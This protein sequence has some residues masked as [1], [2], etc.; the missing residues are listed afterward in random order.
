VFA[1]LWILGAIGVA[2]CARLSG[3]GPW[4]WFVVGVALTPLG[5]S[6]ALMAANRFG[7]FAAR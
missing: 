5:G 2:Y 1:F 3:R 7:W 6:I 4:A